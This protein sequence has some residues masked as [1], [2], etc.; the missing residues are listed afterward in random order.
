MRPIEPDPSPEADLAS[1]KLLS[2]WAKSR[3]RRNNLIKLLG[4]LALL[5][6]TCISVGEVFLYGSMNV[7]AGEALVMALILGVAM[8]LSY[9]GF[10]FWLGWQYG[11][12]G[13]RSGLT[14][15]SVRQCL[16]ILGGAIVAAL[17]FSAMALEGDHHLLRA[18]ILL[19]FLSWIN[20]SAALL[21]YLSRFYSA[22]GKIF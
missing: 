20:A 13:I 14:R 18:G 11:A 7:L 8:A 2:E 5:V 12:L 19:A 1:Q 15:A 6:L 16:G 21:G 22:L 10:L 17:P 4:G 9:S 3:Q